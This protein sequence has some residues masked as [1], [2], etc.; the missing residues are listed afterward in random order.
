MT[1]E[2]VEKVDV[3]KENSNRGKDFRK[4]FVIIEEGQED[5]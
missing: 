2:R 5:N 1:A 4:S 3:T